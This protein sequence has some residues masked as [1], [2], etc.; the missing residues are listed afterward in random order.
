MI[1]INR[2]AKDKE[3]LSL[4]YK[5]EGVLVPLYLSM[6]PKLF[7]DDATRKIIAVTLGELLAVPVKD[8]QLYK[9]KQMGSEA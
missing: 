4:H 5:G 3:W 9:H 7:A 1:L 2:S 8:E 6:A